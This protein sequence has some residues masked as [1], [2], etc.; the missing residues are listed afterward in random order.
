[1]QIDCVRR[2]KSAEPALTGINWSLAL[3][4]NSGKEV[5]NVNNAERQTGEM[6]IIKWEVKGENWR[7]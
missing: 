6:R 7:N 1:M 3:L 5:L 4:H 2:M